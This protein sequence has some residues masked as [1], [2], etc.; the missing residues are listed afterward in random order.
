M[1]EYFRDIGFAHLYIKHCIIQVVVW[2]AQLKVSLDKRDAISIGLVDLFD[3]ITLGH[4]TAYQSMDLVIARNIGK[5]TE[6]ILAI[7]EK[8]L[9]APA[10]DD[11]WAVRQRVIHRQL[12]KRGDATSVEKGQ[13]VGYV[14]KN[15]V[16]LCLF[17][18][19]VAFDAPVKVL[20]GSYNDLP[21]CRGRPVMFL[22]GST[23]AEKISEFHAAGC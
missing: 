9:R 22:V 12:G 20:T 7:A 19:S 14:V 3:C 10:N 11:A 23:M 4:A 2:P 21:G 16:E 1:S 17:F 18:V 15:R 5:R 8:I 13:A 6:D